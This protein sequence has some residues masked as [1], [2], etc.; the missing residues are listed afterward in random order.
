MSLR[1]WR[2]HHVDLLAYL[3]LFTEGF[4]VADLQ[5]AK[6]L[7]DKLRG[8]SW[9]QW[10]PGLGLCGFPDCFGAFVRQ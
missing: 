9:E 2:P 3:Y 8:A 4:D 10:L 7:L 1:F 5:R 6:A